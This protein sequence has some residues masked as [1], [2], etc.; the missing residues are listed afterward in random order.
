MPEKIYISASEV[1]PIYSFYKKSDYLLHEV[2]VTEEDLKFLKQAEE[3]YSKQ[4]KL[5]EDLFNKSTKIVG[6]K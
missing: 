5:L 3:T 1:Y 2:E 6:L 4:Q